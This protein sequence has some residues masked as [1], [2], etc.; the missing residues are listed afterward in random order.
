MSE[1]SFETA[2]AQA[3][4]GAAMSVRFLVTVA[5]AVRERHDEAAA[6]DAGR[7]AARVEQL[8]QLIGPAQEVEAHYGRMVAEQVT[9]PDIREAL[10]RSAAGGDLRRGQQ[11]LHDHQR[12]SGSGDWSPVIG[13]GSHPGDAR[14][15]RAGP[16]RPPPPIRHR[17]GQTAMT[18]PP[19]PVH[20]AHAGTPRPERPTPIKAVDEGALHKPSSG[21]ARDRPVAPGHGGTDALE[22]PVDAGYAEAEA[23]AAWGLAELARGRA[24]EHAER[25]DLPSAEAAAL[26]GVELEPP[27]VS[28]VPGSRGPRRPTATR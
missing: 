1:A 5:A 14:S 3:L 23:K 19:V 27:S 15:R 24:E 12:A 9:N 6:R 4:Q 18:T 22:R 7:E 2:A 20:P 21:P 25:G 17:K 11:P 10:L 28:A 8:R 26:E 16:A 13:R